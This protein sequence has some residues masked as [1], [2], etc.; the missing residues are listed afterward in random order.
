MEKTIILVGIILFGFNTRKKD[1]EIVEEF[2]FDQIPENYNCSVHKWEQNGASYSGNVAH[3]K[4]TVS[5]INDLEYE[6]KIDPIYYSATEDSII[7]V[8][9]LS[10]AITFYDM[11]SSEFLPIPQAF[12]SFQKTGD[13]THGSI[14]LSADEKKD[15]FEL[16]LGGMS[17]NLFLKCSYPENEYYLEISGNKNSK[18]AELHFNLIV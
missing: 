8:P 9:N 11:H 14:S 12:F 7:H 5:K 3:T 1:N 18:L 15:K 17:I 6:I 4:L 13:F 10:I 2:P 16:L